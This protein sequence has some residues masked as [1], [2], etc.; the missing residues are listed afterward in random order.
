MWEAGV[1]CMD[2]PQCDGAREHEGYFPEGCPPNV[3]PYVITS[4]ANRSNNKNV[5]AIILPNSVSLH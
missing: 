3:L 1:G 5:E 4:R 2:V